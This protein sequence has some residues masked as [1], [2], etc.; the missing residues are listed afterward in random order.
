MAVL[1]IDVGSSSVRALLFDTAAQL[2]PDALCAEGHQFQTHPDGQSTADPQAVAQAVERCLDVILKH[3]A[4]AQIQ[5][6]GMATFVTSLIGLDAA[7][8][9]L[10]PLYSY[11]DTRCASSVTWLMQRMDNG[12]VYQQTGCPLHTAYYP[13]KLHWLK[14]IQPEQL[15]RVHQWVD[16]G[17]YLYRRWFGREIPMSVSS[18]SWTGLLDAQAEMK[19]GE[20]E[21]AYDLLSRCDL[22]GVSLPELADYT[23]PQTTLSPAYAQRWAALVNVPFYLPV[24]DGAAANIGSGAVREDQLALTIGTTAAI[25]Q[26][27]PFNTKMYDRLMQRQNASNRPWVYRLNQASMLVGGATYEGGN[28]FQWAQQ[29]LNLAGADIE[30]E[31][32]RREADSHQL[33]VL[34][35]LSG[36]RSPGWQS[37]AVG[38]IHGLRLSSTPID[39]LQA[40]LE[41]VAQRL[42]LVAESLGAGSVMAGGG[43][44]VAS[45]AWGQIIA[46]TMNRPLHLIDA[47]EVTARGVA[48]MVL[49]D[50]AGLSW[51]APPPIQ[52][53]IQPQPEQVDRLQQARQRH[54]LLYEQQYLS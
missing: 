36:E 17:I 26:I 43:A 12:A 4:A 49:H 38:I 37:Q 13:A 45:P 33:T 25:R 7:G 1:V 20:A 50:H 15:N 51:D 53:V 54:L 32:L 19:T 5:A 21:W 6:V 41:G 28:I 52:T 10:T 42:A 46:N 23:T 27:M 16:I 48:L 35:H 11:A 22:A 3:P 8:N 30:A 47:P 39:I 40:A 14:Q 31:L 24:G 44:L 2:I 9:P 18:A 29:T 34:P